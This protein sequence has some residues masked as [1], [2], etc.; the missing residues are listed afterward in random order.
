[1]AAGAVLEYSAC[2]FPKRKFWRLIPP[3]AGAAIVAV[4]TLFRY[5]GWDAQGV[6]G[7]PLETLLFFP[8]LSALGLFIGFFL[9][10]R[11]WK[12]LW[13]PKV[14]HEKKEDQNDQSGK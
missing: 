2:R 9:G 3:I 10:W 4:I 12:H 6:Q 11:G 7:A 8:G 1:M 13:T 5:H 14:F